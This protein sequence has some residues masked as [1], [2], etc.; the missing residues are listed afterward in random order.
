[1]KWEETSLQVQSYMWFKSGLTK[2]ISGRVSLEYIFRV[3]TH[4]RGIFRS[5]PNTHTRWM[6]SG[7]IPAKPDVQ[8][9]Q[10]CYS[11]SR[12]WIIRHFW[13]WIDRIL[14]HQIDAWQSEHRQSVRFGPTSR[15]CMRAKRVTAHHPPSCALRRPSFFSALPVPPPRSSSSPT[16]RRGG[17]HLPN[18]PVRLA[19]SEPLARS[20]HFHR[21]FQ[22]VLGVDAFDRACSPDRRPVGPRDNARSGRGANGGPAPRLGLLCEPWGAHKE[23]R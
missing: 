15:I 13:R 14:P 1:M 3:Y 8:G 21:E 9:Y 19:F 4:T 6:S 12:F 10:E 23:R 2:S 20:L 22:S 18:P 7:Q 11:Y 16:T 17:G 5:F